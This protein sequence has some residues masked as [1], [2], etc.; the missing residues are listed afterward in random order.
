MSPGCWALPTDSKNT[1]S[2]RLYALV[3]SNIDLPFG[4]GRTAAAGAGEMLALLCLGWQGSCKQSQ[5]V[6][7][8]WIRTFL[9]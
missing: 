4:V 5:R 7:G 1:V 2:I 3:V 8:S 9:F 6:T